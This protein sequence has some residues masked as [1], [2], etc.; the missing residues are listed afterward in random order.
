VTHPPFRTIRAERA[1]L[2]IEVG[3]FRAERANRPLQATLRCGLECPSL[4]HVAPR[5]FAPTQLKSRPF[6]LEE[7][8]LAG[9]TRHQLRG[10]SWQRIE[11]GVYK[12]AKLTDNPLFQLVAISRR[13]PEAAFSGYTAGWL[14]GLDLPPVNPVE[15][16]VQNTSASN[17]AGV[18]LRR[19]RLTPG[20]VVQIKGLA[21]TSAL[22]TV[23][24]VGSRP[25]LVAAVVALD[26]ALHRRIVSLTKLRSDVEANRGAK[27]IA[28]LRRAIGLA[29]PATQ[30]P[31][32][33]RLR[34]LLVMAGSPARRLR[35][36]STIQSV[37]SSVELTFITRLT[38]LVSSTTAAP[39]GTISSKT[40][41]AKIVC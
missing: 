12:W 20:D 33:T 10:R 19:A 5:P 36:P 18:C 30:S 27:G 21:V 25:P 8:T 28:T 37:V 41:D 31:M 32:E 13:L 17:R 4:P 9:L 6:T 22:R 7:A 35:S 23:V 11:R 3:R 1:Y 40:T 14:H 24:D 34:L 29:E 16:T 2:G 15:V 38:S 39:T 26:M